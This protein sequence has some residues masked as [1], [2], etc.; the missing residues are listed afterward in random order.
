M[1]FVLFLLLALPGYALADLESD[2][3]AAREAL[4][5]GDEARLDRAAERLKATPMEPYAT[6]FQLR[7]NVG[8]RNTAPIKAFLARNVES[9]IV[10]Q[11]RGEWLK[12]LAKR[13]QWTTFAGTN[14]R[15]NIRIW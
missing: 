3:V 12:S 6:Y 15:R 11:F 4:R 10:D 5:E 9:P 8:M 13:E 2:F 1:K 7:M 14:L